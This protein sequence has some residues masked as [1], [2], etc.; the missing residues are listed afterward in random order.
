MRRFEGTMNGGGGKRQRECHTL[1]KREVGRN[2]EG[3]ETCE[4]GLKG[5]VSCD[6]CKVDKRGHLI[7]EAATP[8][9]GPEGC[10]APVGVA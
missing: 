2:G 4:S 1:I 9:S 3:R 7:H 8:R 6:E 10:D 5:R